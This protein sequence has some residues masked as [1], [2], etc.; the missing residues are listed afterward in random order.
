MSAP[1][2]SPA[3][4]TGAPLREGQNITFIS[5]DEPH[6]YTG[7]VK[8]IGNEQ[9]VVESGKHFF[10]LGGTE[11]RIGARGTRPQYLN[12]LALPEPRPASED[13]RQ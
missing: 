6:L 13:S 4:Y 11:Q 10:I 5:P 12:V 7:Q 8:L 9:L 1:D 3:D 2:T